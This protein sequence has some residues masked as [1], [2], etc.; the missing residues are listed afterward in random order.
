MPASPTP[1]AGPHARLGDTIFAVAHVLALVAVLIY[2][3]IG[4]IN[5][6]VGRFG[7]VVVGL[8]LYYALVLHKGVV[9]EIK[10][11]RA[12]PRP[13]APRRKS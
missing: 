8:A 7:L 2:G 13:A 9:K 11:R 1:P 3:V 5:R 4:L 12:L 6:N 10:R